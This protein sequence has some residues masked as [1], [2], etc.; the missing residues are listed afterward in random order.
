MRFE[1]ENELLMPQRS[2][3]FSAGYDFYLPEGITIAPYASV[4][5][6]LKV[7]AALNSNQVLMLFVRSSIAINQNVTLANTV[8]IIDADFYPN[9]IIACLR[10]NT[11]MPIKLVKGSRVCQGIIVNYCLADNDKDDIDKSCRRGGIGST[12]K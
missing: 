6:D 8:G 3:Q 7:A 10:N 12:G 5:V 4:K 11:G 1:T 2:T 9:T